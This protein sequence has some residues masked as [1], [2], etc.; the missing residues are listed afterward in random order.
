[1]IIIFTVTFLTDVTVLIVS[2]V[3]NAVLIILI[4]IALLLWHKRHKTNVQLVKQKRDIVILKCLFLNLLFTLAIQS[5]PLT[6]SLLA[7]CDVLVININSLWLFQVICISA[8][9]IFRVIRKTTHQG[10]FQ[11]FGE[12]RPIRKI[13]PLQTHDK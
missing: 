7:S 12:N 3:N 4:D 11:C 1:M 9:A 5:F 13:A 8:H 6:M 2:A 10:N